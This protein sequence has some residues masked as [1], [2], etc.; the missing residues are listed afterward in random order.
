MPWFW[1]LGARV[2][3]DRARDRP[4]SDPTAGHYFSE[5]L[6]AGCSATR[7][8]PPGYWLDLTSE[9][10]AIVTKNAGDASEGVSV[11]PL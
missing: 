3:D 2:L 4:I 7:P 6:S 8:A 9:L 11:V 10:P 1:A 5:S